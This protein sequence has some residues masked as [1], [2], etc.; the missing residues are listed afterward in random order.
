MITNN[1]ILI[2]H[3]D[4]SKREQLE[5]ARDD[6]DEKYFKPHVLQY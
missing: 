1:L 2:I 3:S 6:D 4:C 5:G